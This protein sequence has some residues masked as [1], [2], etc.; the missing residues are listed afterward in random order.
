MGR[1]V[2]R[3]RAAA[4]GVGDANPQRVMLMRMHWVLQTD[5][6]G[7]PICSLVAENFE[8]RRL[9]LL[10][11]RNRDDMRDLQP[12]SEALRLRLENPT[13]EDLKLRIQNPAGG[14]PPE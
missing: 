9:I 11:T 12:N 5:R 14:W 10:R 3:R 6:E 1:R 2:S 13:D 7:D 8:G 4:V